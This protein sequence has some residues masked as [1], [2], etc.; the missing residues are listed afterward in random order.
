MTSFSNIVLTDVFY[1]SACIRAAG[2]LIHDWTDATAA[3]HHVYLSE[4]TEEYV[5]G[6]FYQREL[7]HLI[8]ILSCFKTFD[9]VV[10][11]AHVWLQKDKPGCGHYLWKQLE[12]RIPVIGVAKRSFHDGV[13]EPILR[14]DSQ[15][16]LF[17]T[18]IGVDL[19]L[20]KQYILQMHGPYRMP[21]MLKSVDHLSRHETL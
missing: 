14:G 2:I 17:I 11:D 4:Q 9:C 21:T 10:V 1:G 19:Q 16:P 12:E 18:A 13:A 20:A 7:P 15:N 5:S 6:S 3:E 8:D